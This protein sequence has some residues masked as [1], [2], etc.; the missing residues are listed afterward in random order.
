MKKLVSIVFISVVGLTFGQQ[1]IQFTQTASSPFLINPAAGGLMN[2]AEVVLGNRMQ[3]A[4]IDGRPMTT[5]AGIQS[6]VRFKKRKSKALLSELSS[7]G[8]TFYSTPQ[9]TVAYK[10][11]AGLTFINDIIGPFTRTSVKGNIGVHIPLSQKLSAG[12]GIGIG[13]SNFGIDNSKVTL[14][15]AN[16]KAYANY[17]GIAASQNYLDAQAGLVVYNDRLLVSLSGSQIF[18]NKMRLS[19][20]TTESTFQPHLFMLASYRFDIGKNYGLEPIVQFR[21]V[22]HAPV[23]YDVAMRLH[24]QRLGWL[25]LSYRRQSAIGVGFGINLLSRFNVS[26]CFEFG[27]GVTEK[28]GNTSHEIRLG[29]IFGH[30]RNM[31]KEFKQDEKLN[32]AP[33][34]TK[35]EE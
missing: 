5:F 21:S 1:D 4:G 14:G 25:S 27:S 24:Y 11:V 2:V 18:N 9:R 6:M 20:V 15:T 28:F 35:P 23:S 17:I 19:D 22:K 8:Q 12:I 34:E 29:F 7:I 26:Y 13:W 3:Y 30:K 33:T 10:Q 32:P 31:N 16:D